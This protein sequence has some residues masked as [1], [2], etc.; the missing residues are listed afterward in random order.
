MKETREN[1]YNKLA[2]FVQDNNFSVSI[3][4][5]KMGNDILAYPFDVNFTYVPVGEIKLE[6][7]EINGKGFKQRG[8][9]ILPS[10]DKKLKKAKI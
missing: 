4:Y 9:Y 5:K 1:F 7:V 3:G 8:Y 2:K 6:D 10:I